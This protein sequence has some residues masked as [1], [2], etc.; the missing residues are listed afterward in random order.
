MTTSLSP[1]TT[2]VAGP[3]TS[4]Q[5]RAELPP[6][7]TNHDV[8]HRADPEPFFDPRPKPTAVDDRGRHPRNL[9]RSHAPR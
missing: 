9:G 6:F 7:H 3:F 5:M 8:A 2:T 4:F 1:T